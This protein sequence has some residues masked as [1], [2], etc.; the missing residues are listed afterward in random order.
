M[1]TEEKSG[2]VSDEAKDSW[3]VSDTRRRSGG[4]YP[5]WV[6]LGPGSSG[7]R[8]KVRGASVQLWEFHMTC[9]Q[10]RASIHFFPSLA[11]LFWVQ[12]DHSW[13]GAFTGPSNSSLSGQW[14][15]CVLGSQDKW[16]HLY[17]WSRHHVEAKLGV[18]STLSP[19]FMSTF[20][21]VLTREWVHWDI[22]LFPVFSESVGHISSTEL[23]LHF[24][25]KTRGYFR[26]PNPVFLP[27]KSH[28]QRRLVGHSSRGCKDTTE[29]LNNSNFKTRY[30]FK[31]T[32]RHSTSLTYSWPHQKMQTK[33]R[34]WRTKRQKE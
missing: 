18:G 23:T 31:M 9:A 28:G 30:H 19:S 2:E 27:G 17:P 22:P 6:Q 7:L 26:Q 11:W 34:Y 10:S 5:N 33:Q 24:P 21:S 13:R 16:S 1:W 25:L 20:P 14:S 4:S 32:C 3:E 15:S 8:D 12:K 29:Q